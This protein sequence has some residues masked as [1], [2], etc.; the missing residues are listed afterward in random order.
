MHVRMHVCMHVG[1]MSVCMDVSIAGLLGCWNDVE[2]SV[3][4]LHAACEFTH[5]K[6]ACMITRPHLSTDG[7]TSDG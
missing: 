7:Q 2:A 4:M 6:Y 1:Y 3:S 5:V